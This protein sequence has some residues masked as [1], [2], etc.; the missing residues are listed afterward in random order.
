MPQTARE[1]IF[2]LLPNMASY[3]LISYIRG[4]LIV[5]IELNVDTKKL[6]TLSR[7]IGRKSLLLPFATPCEEFPNNFIDIFLETFVPRE[8]QWKANHANK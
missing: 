3:I 2:H 5:T 7:K 4:R 8:A 1:E 6:K